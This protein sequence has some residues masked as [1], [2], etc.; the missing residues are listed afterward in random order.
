MIKEMIKKAAD[1]IDL[2]YDE[3]AEVTREIMTGNTTPAQTA[4]Y[5]TALHIKGET[6]DEIS[7]S[8]FVM[9]DVATPVN[10]SGEVLE[11]VGTG[12]D[13]SNSINISTISALV[14]AAAG[15]KV[16]KHGNRAASSKCGTADCLEALGVNIATDPS[17]CVK[18]LDEAGMCF[19]FAQKYHSAMKYVGPV[20]KEIGIPTIFN[21]LGPLTNPA[22]PTYQLLGV[23]KPELLEPMAKSLVKLGVKRGMAVYGTEKLDEISVSAPTMV[24]EFNGDSFNKYEITPEQFGIS[25]HDKSELV[26]GTPDEN[27]AAAKRILSGEQGAGRDAVLLNAGAALHIVK[28]ISLEDGIQLAAQTIDSGAALKTLEKYIAV[29]NEVK[30]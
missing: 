13:G 7:A 19:L 14:C 22:H 3:A 12:G 10:Y 15:V 30:A 20:R 1:G 5:L 26:G 2:T 4:A 25:R 28:G 17:G 29:S 11:I 9:R 18:L 6:A 16:A 8:A 24:L 23:Y 21:V 27:A